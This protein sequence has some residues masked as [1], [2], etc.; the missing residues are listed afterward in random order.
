M[1]H[2]PTVQAMSLY[3]MLLKPHRLGLQTV[4]WIRVVVFLPSLT[5]Q[6]I[7]HFTTLAFVFTSLSALCVA[8]RYCTDTQYLL[9]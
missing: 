6:V 8:V 4:I 2:N 5:T 3:K 7:M 1:S 9:H